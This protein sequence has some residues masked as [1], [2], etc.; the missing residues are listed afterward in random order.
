M[1]KPVGAACNLAC[2]YC[3]Y[4][5]KSRLYD[6]PKRS[7]LS[8]ELLEKFVRE[9]IEMQDAPS[10]LFT[11]H[12][13]EPTLRPVS[14][15]EKAIRLQEKYSGGKPID[16]AFQT[17]G[18][19]ITD[20][21]ARFFKRHNFLVGVS[22]DGPEDMHDEY[23]RSRHGRPS[24]QQVMR[25]IRTL[26]RHGVEWNA[27][28]VVNDF[29][30]HHPL[31]FYHFFKDIGCRYIQF[32]PV[33]ERFYKHPDGRLLA[34]PSDGALAQMAPFSVTAA[35]WGAFLCELFV[36][37]VKTDVGEYFIQLFDSTLAGWMGVAPSVC[38]LAER[39]GHAAVMEF[40]GDVY[41]CDHYVFPEY[42]LGNL[43]EQPLAEMMRS[44]GLA[45][46]GTD[47]ARLLT[48]QCRECEFLMACHGECPKNRFGVS[49]HGEAG[50]NNL[51]GGN[52]RFFAHAAPCMDFM[53]YR[54]LRQEPPAAVMEWVAQG[55][56]EFRW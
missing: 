18:T 50:H 8:D 30:V 22:I 20:E 24:F 23:R 28:A 51:C 34:A 12:G 7:L 16:N 1:L 25:G 27:M 6:S 38:T 3:Y 41:A 14:F 43:K 36:E 52:K 37:W 55:L 21:W 40:N 5:E 47:K 19:L 9:Y 10:V 39:C 32:T 13:G 44:E 48:R 54:L 11:W 53:K 17:N 31:E 49:I 15:Y 42:K 35:D 29:N 4:L 56:P 2:D 46:F 45:R 26:N 33:V